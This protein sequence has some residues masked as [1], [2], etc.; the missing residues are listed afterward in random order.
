M[1]F[2]KLELVDEAK[3]VLL[4]SWTSIL[5]GLAVVFGAL[6][7]M[8]SHLSLLQPMLG[9]KSYAFLVLTADAA[10]QIGIAITAA[11]PFARVV[12]QRRLSEIAARALRNSEVKQ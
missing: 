11:I 5:A 8:Q 4:T 10:P 12:K 1:K 6:G 3:T 7:A 2:E 9:P